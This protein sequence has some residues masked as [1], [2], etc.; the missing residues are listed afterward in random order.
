MS[1]EMGLVAACGFCQGFLG[2]PTIM[3]APRI[4]KV[5]ADIWAIPWKQRRIANTFCLVVI[6]I[7]AWLIHSAIAKTFIS[8]ADAHD[9]S[10]RPGKFWALFVF[11]GCLSYALVPGIEW[12]IRKH[13]MK[14]GASQDDPSRKDK[15]D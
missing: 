15:D 1:F 10:L 9:H 6:F 11:F 4:A 12:R 14:G 3:L 8:M 2:F 5:V 13:F 7:F